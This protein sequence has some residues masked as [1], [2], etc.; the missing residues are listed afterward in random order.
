MIFEDLP[1]VELHCHLLGTIS[2]AVLK[3]IRAQG[4]PVLAEPE[5]LEAALPVR[6]LDSF[7]RWLDVLRPYQAATTEAMRPVLAAHAAALIAQNVVYAEI[8][9]SPTMFPREQSALLAD[10][11][12]W[13]D[14][15]FALEQGRIQI[16]FLMVVPRTLTPEALDRDTANFLALHR[17]G[18]IAG[19][20]LVG[21]ETGE[22]LARF[23]PWFTRWRDAGLGLEIH[24][25]EHTGKESVRDALDYGS[26][27][28]LGHAIGAFEDADLVEQ[29][30]QRGVHVEFCLTSNLCTGVVRNLREHPIVE[31]RERGLSF[32]LNTDDPGAFDCCL[33]GEYRKAAE[34]CGFTGEDFRKAYEQS[35]AARFERNLRYPPP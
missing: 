32:G 12:R 16:E 11:S 1:K 33:N 35:L 21:V 9:L 23:R 30:R 15:A 25:G 19:V 14:W 27:H 3:S 31:A 7:R 26:P 22:S 4:G 24:A 10:F 34:A 5:A 6:D 13:R 8:M 18:L 28:R 17:A 29:I 20:A 2:P